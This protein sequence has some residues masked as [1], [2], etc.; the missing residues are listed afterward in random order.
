M[1]M[2]TAIT[3]HRFNIYYIFDFYFTENF[4]HNNV[5]SFRI[6]M[7]ITGGLLLCIYSISDKHRN[8]FE[9]TSFSDY[10]HIC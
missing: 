8:K 4:I 1:L 6:S 10:R 5:K 3:G 7:Y 9:N 2:Q